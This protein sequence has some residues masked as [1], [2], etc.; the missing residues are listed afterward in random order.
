MAWNQA[1]DSEHDRHQKSCTMFHVL[2]SLLTPCLRGP[3]PDRTS[4]SDIKSAEIQRVTQNL[5]TVQKRNLKAFRPMLKV[6]ADRFQ[7]RRITVSA[8]NYPLWASARVCRGAA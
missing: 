6:C 3:P 1:S 4:C 2:F 5:N 7:V 8:F